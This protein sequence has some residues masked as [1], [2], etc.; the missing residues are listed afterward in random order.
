MTGKE[1][2]Q[3]ARGTLRR[4][5]SFLVALCL[6]GTLLGGTWTLSANLA[7]TAR[8]QTA[9][10]V[11]TALLPLELD[12]PRRLF[13]LAT[14]GSDASGQLWLREGRLARQGSGALSRGGGVLA[15][16]LNKWESG[17]YMAD[18]LN[19]LQ[20]RTG[21]ERGGLFAL[22]VLCAAGV[23]IFWLLVKNIY[24]AG[25]CRVLLEC[26][27]YRSVP[28]GEVF[29]P[30]RLGCWGRVAATMGMRSLRLL[31]WSLSLVGIPERLCAYFPVPY[32][33]AENPQLGW[34][35][36]LELS[37]RMMEGHKWAYARLELSFLGWRLLSILT[38]GLSGALYSGPY[39]QAAQSHF[40]VA[41]RARWLEENPEY[42]AV[43][44][45]PWLFQ[46]PDGAD[47]ARAYDDLP[48]P[49]PIPRLDGLKGF[50][51]RN[52]GLLTQL[53]SRERAYARAVEE[54]ASLATVTAEATGAGYPWR[55]APRKPR[56][57]WDGGLACRSRC[58]WTWSV[59]AQF[60]VF[61]W[62]GW[63]WEVG[64]TSVGTGQ[65]VNRGVLHG[66]WLP[67][68]GFGACFILTLLYRFRPR[69]GVEFL[70][71]VTLCGVLEYFTGLFMELTHGGQ[72]WWDY[73]DHF[74]NLHGR[75]C[76][77]GLL[78]FGI[79]GMVAVYLLAPWLDRLLSRVPR[80][81]LI[82]VC[83]ILLALFVVDELWSLAS[84][85]A[86][87]GITNAALGASAGP[88]GGLLP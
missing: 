67:I 6:G 84:P 71:A 51:A 18:A 34:R 77:E 17:A 36:T 57:S 45:D 32:L 27:T 13:Q 5:Y 40:Y 69:P 21:S 68:Y 41:L 73:Q 8:T 47:L 4:H 83:L 86:G 80:Q 20:R 85:N 63:L 23:L 76:A 26:R 74:L 30:A 24:R 66:P 25:C 62:I 70:L 56:W 15:Q 60:F 49:Q 48:V 81:V 64:Y 58:Y 46:V 1:V 37:E 3:A 42:E 43:L 53:E 31:L 14:G 2:K 39:R 19:A 82:R 88:P 29:W 87:P 52:F 38:L 28:F 12:V 79:G 33:V 54:H 44:D 22:A 78:L 7:R 50:L 55:L 11:Q 75:V 16:A 72:R 59:L 61:A 65:L 10:T 35:R 9:P